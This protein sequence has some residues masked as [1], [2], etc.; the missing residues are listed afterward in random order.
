MVTE[1]GNVL[2]IHLLLN[3]GA[4][5]AFDNDTLEVGGNIDS[6]FSDEF[7][8]LLVDETNRYAHQILDNKQSR[9]QSPNSDWIDTMVKETKSLFGLMCILG[10]VLY[11]ELKVIR[12][13]M[14]C[15]NR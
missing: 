13:Q 3:P 14:L 9:R 5:K 2:T 1:V 10:H 15:S 7:W 11:H 4:K 12:L 8:T 6:I